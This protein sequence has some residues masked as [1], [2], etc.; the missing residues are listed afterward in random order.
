MTQRQSK[1]ITADAFPE[2]NYTQTP[3]NFFDML[4]DMEH[5]EVNVTLIMIRETF[6]YHRNS[7]KMG[8]NKLAEATGLSRN[9][10]KDGAEA[11]ERRGTF[12]R[13]NPD[14]QSEAE[15]ELVVGQPVTT[16]GQPVTTSPS[17]NDPQVGVKETLNKELKKSGKPLDIFSALEKYE[18][19][20]QT[21]REAIKEYFRLNI[22]WETKQ[23]R[24]WMEWAVGEQIT[25]EQIKLAAEYWRRDKLFNWTVPTLKGIFEKWPLLMGEEKKSPVSEF[26]L[27]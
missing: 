7:F 20:A 17:T 23:A 21:L 27:L 24:Q 13:I 9:A 25:P 3:N 1:Y 2:P 16:P 4:P 26:E 19:P 15:W 8:I 18:K 12:R 6:G 14:K 5:S 10:T 22:N 11:A